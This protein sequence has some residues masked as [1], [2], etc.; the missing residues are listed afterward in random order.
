ME[1]E[2]FQDPPPNSGA[3]ALVVRVTDDGTTIGV[4]VHVVPAH[5]VT[6]PPQLLAGLRVTPEQAYE[7][8][9]HFTKCAMAVEDYWREQ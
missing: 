7:I 8:A 9:Q 4:G 6:G 1:F 3:T 2:E 5:G